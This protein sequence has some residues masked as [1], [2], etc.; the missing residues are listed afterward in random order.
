[1]RKILFG[2]IFFSSFVSY[3]NIMRVKFID[4]K[5]EIINFTDNSKKF[6]KIE[7]VM[8][9]V[10]KITEDDKNIMISF[11]QAKRPLSANKVVISD[12]FGKIAEF[13]VQTTQELIAENEMADVSKVIF[14]K[15][16][17]DTLKKYQMDLV[18][19]LNL[20]IIMIKLN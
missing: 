16:E 6:A 12:S 3:S 20:L 13:D 11:V 19:L 1:M 18:L 7:D 5:Y 2:L 15:D 4:D 14:G 10:M 9:P 8:V 17:L